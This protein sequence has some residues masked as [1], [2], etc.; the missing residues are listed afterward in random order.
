MG[1]HSA[2]Q[3]IEIAA[4]PDA[5]FE[6]I[7]DYESFTG[8]QE[9]VQAVDVQDRYPDGLG[10][11]VELEVDA[12]VRTVRYRLEYRYERPRRITWDFL[13]GRGI[14]HIEG[15]YLFEPSG[16]GTLATYRVGIDPGVRVPGILARRLNKGVMRRSVEELKAETERRRG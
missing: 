15:E 4:P 14:E 5:C 11:T 10:R 13:E 9:A 8:W 7:T 16:D 1:V 12:K 3:Q 6:T 2:E